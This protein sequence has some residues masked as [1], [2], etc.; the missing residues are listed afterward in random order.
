MATF[1]TIKLEENLTKEQQDALRALFGDAIYEFKGHRHPA[2]EYM[3]RRC[4]ADKVFT[5]PESRGKKLASIKMRNELA[6]LLH[7]PV[8]RLESTVVDS[9]D[10]KAL[11]RRY[12]K[13]ALNTELDAIIDMA[14]IDMEAALSEEKLPKDKVDQ[15]LAAMKE[16]GGELKRLVEEACLELFNKDELEFMTA[17][18][19]SKEG[20]AITSRAA[21][22]GKVC[23][24]SI[25]IW[26][27]SVRQRADEVFPIKREGPPA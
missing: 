24:A 20:K 23:D 1:I 27:E 17:F 16:T 15:F 21:D 19:E 12:V 4:P 2:E 5:D 11:V 8:L 10:E 7:T 26:R 13:A 25:D 22:L 14:L 6:E 18:F 3:E 9:S